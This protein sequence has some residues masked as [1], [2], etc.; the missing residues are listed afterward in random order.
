MALIVNLLPTSLRYMMVPLVAIVP[1][2]EFVTVSMNVK[3]SMVCA[4]TNTDDVIK[5]LHNVRSKN[6]FIIIIVAV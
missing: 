5:R 4:D 3:L 6:S 2:F 1:K